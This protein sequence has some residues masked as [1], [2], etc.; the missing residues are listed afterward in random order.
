MRV[1]WL[2][3]LVLLVLTPMPL[4]AAD[5]VHVSPTGNDAHPGTAERPVASLRRAVELVADRKGPSEIILREG[6]YPGDVRVGTQQNLKDTGVPPLLIRA[7]KKPDGG[8]QD[9]ILDGSRRVR[10]AEPVPGKAGVYKI[11]GAYT[12]SQEPG[13]WEEDTRIR[14]TLVADMTAVERYPASFWHNGKEVFFHTSDRQPPSAHEIG[15]SK[16]RAG[17]TLWRPNTTVQGIQFR[18]FLEWRWSCGL[19]LRAQNTAGEDCRAWNCVRGFQIMMEAP[20]TRILRCRAD[21]CGGGVYSQGRQSLIEDGRFFKIRDR[22][23]VSVY[24]QD[25]TG[26]QFYHPAFGGEV[27]RNLCVGF[28]NGIFVKCP[29]SPF[30]VE[31]N[32]CVDGITYGI[33]CTTWHKES[34]FRLNIVCGFSIPMLFSPDNFPPTSVL[35]WNCIW[36]ASRRT[37]DAETASRSRLAD[38]QRTGKGK[39]SIVA[40]PR[41]A[42]PRTNPLDPALPTQSQSRLVRG[43]PAAGD[44]RLLPSSPCAALGPKGETCGAFGVVEPGFKDVQPPSLAVT[45]DAPARPLTAANLYVESQAW[46]GGAPGRLLSAPA[47][48]NGGEWLS[49][50]G[51]VA[52]RLEARDHA[53]KVTQMSLR[54]GEEE[55]G[56]PQAFQEH[57]SVAL[58]AGRIVA[59]GV[60]VCDDAGN[61]SEPVVLTVRAVSGGPKITAGPTARANKHGALV[62]FETDRPC[63]VKV[64]TGEASF[65]NPPNRQ[66]S[67]VPGGG[68][69][70]AQRRA[71]TR[72]LT[73]VAFLP[74]TVKDGATARYA[75][76]LQDETGAE[77]RIPDATLDLKGEPVTFYVSPSG[78]DSESGGSAAKPW[79]TLQFALDRV[80]PGDRVVLRAGLYPGEAVLAHGGVEGA[81]ITIES[82]R[83]GVA[84][85]DGR[86]LAPTC[87]RLDRAP[88][89]VIKGLEARWFGES[90]TF[91]SGD[92]AGI[93]ITESPNVSVLN[94]RMWNGFWT[95]WPIGSGLYAGKSP[96]LTASRNIIHQVEQG[97]SLVESPRS[98]IEHNTILKNM[99]GAVKFIYSAEGS[100]SRNNSFCFSGNDQYLVIYKDKKEFDAFYSDYNN[101][102]TRLRSPDPGDEIVP[103]DPFFRGVG[104][105]A[106]ISLNGERYN[107]LRAWQKATG[108]D[109]HSIFKDPKYADAA[110]WD[111]RLKP[112][113]PNLGA[114]QSGATIGASGLWVRGALGATTD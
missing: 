78:E 63:R 79:R 39:N 105:K 50:E 31:N 26:I 95:G 17:I 106:V 60:K 110:R 100:V 101:L 40:D 90:S 9:V 4:F 14:Y 7:A 47:E 3:Q 80:L 13:M 108:K 12:Y 73:H 51:K 11:P 102:G 89:V 72:V 38:L 104:S 41:F 82:E 36:G 37:S 16:G 74:P 8:F 29:E 71:N 20:N 99:Y 96:G 92:K 57:T 48:E 30:I 107:S 45:A 83:D 91:Y 43:A 87:L 46:M 70:W 54:V 25:D 27:R 81:P 55:W 86:H 114:G 85:L 21:D 75:L 15:M 109:L 42:A 66:R 111:F 93:F 84:V 68:P 10:E 98:R 62:W 53:G 56:N 18:H 28:C 34:V 61:W 67:W 113:S 88:H 103:E 1:P 32:T 23:R 76:T 5:A 35:D 22:F 94:C 24:P 58:P 77:S 6:V 69:S 52:L 2:L 65:E 64:Q 49:P 59:V 97:I 19:E 44:Y 33:G 112:G